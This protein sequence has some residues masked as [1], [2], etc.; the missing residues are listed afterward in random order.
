MD[1]RHLAAAAGT[2]ATLALAAHG[3]VAATT[4]NALFMSQAA[5]SESDVRAMT[6]D[7]EKVHPDI[8]VNLEFVPY[9]AL[10]DKIV[11]AAGAG[12]RGYDVVL[13]DTIWPAEFAQRG[14]LKDVTDKVPAADHAKVFDGAW[15]TA[16]YGGKLYGMPWILDTK[17]LY[18]NKAMVA[19]AG[20]AKPPATWAELEQDAATI[21]AKGIVKFPIVW[22]WSQSE[23]MICDYTTIAA[24]Y[25][26]SFLKDGKPAFQAGGSVD[27][28]KFMRETLAKGLSNPS[29]LE[30]LEED[31]RKAFSNGDAAFSLNWTY[32]YAMAEDPKT[33]KIVGQ[34][35]IAPAPGVAG[36]SKASAVNGSM[37]LGIAANSAHPAEAW[38]YITYL[39][40]QPVQ[41]KYAK[42]SLPI[43]K[44]SYTDPAVAK[45]QEPLFKAAAVSLGLMTSRPTTPRYTQLSDIL[46]K[47]IHSALLGETAPQA[48]LDAAAK[49]A[50]RLR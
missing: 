10:H 32:A 16:T 49:R 44:S 14:F 31:V 30:Y 38:T 42:L 37:G 2:A 26:G 8:K 12:D 5:Y 9:E 11:A 33:S 21:K 41:N 29:S 22:S 4:L 47:N 3:A 7:F 39:T 46:Q 45:G 43:W 20:I 35:G 18:Y 15:S 17:Y 13:F 1:L 36:V 19:K 23:A 40:S 50:E 48:A 27:A 34:V 24:A 6:A 25:G 28:V